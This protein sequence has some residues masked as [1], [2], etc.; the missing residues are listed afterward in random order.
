MSE[1]LSV[2]I[3]QI[4]KE[5]PAGS[6]TVKVRFVVEQDGSLSDIKAL[7]DPGY[8]IAEKIT[9]VLKRSPKW[10]PARQNGRKVRA[11]YTQ[12]VTLVLTEEKD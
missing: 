4:D 7:N 11:Y 12:P 9:E 5:A 10:T 6:Y 2:V 1:Q 3:P 8:G